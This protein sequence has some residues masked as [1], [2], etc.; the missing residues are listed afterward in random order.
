MVISTWNGKELMHKIGVEPLVFKSGRLKDGLSPARDVT[1]EERVLFQ[2]M[3]DEMFDS[4][5]QIVASGRNIPLETV[6]ASPIG[7][8]RIFTATQALELKLIDKIGYLEDA[9]DKLEELTGTTDAHVFEYEMP[10]SLLNTLMGAE[11]E[12]TKDVIKKALPE[13][14]FSK[15]GFYYLTPG[16]N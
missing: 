16:F 12:T 13:I 2:G 15:S 9:I 10:P 6:K 8:A 14:P 1:E 4:F 7:D 3:V 5:A 11:A